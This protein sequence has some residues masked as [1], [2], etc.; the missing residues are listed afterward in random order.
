MSIDLYPALDLGLTDVAVALER[1]VDAGTVAPVGAAS[2]FYRNED[3][4]WPEDQ[5]ADLVSQFPS[6]EPR[7]LA[8]DNATIGDIFGEQLP[9]ID[10]DQ[11]ATLVT[12]TAGGNDLLSAFANKPRHDLLVRIA[13]DIADAY[14][15]LVKS[16]REARPNSGLVL[17]TIYDP[18]DGT[19]RVPGVL[20]SAGPMPL[21]VLER[22]NGRIRRIADDTEGAIVADVHAHFLGHGVSAPEKER[23]YWR[24]SLIEPNAR[25]ASEIRHV[26]LESLQQLQ[27][28]LD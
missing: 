13:D 4:Q 28:V 8:Q 20:E 27:E 10:E 14:D 7:I 19:G 5:G 15:F 9:G 6:I 12:L 22:L 18:S 17:T 3:E 23:W 24:R 21:D 1:S 2:L 25:G 26:W 11:E 16:I